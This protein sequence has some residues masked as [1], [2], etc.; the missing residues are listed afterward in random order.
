MTRVRLRYTK[1]GKIRFIG[2]RDLARTWE[3]ALRRSGLAVASTE[4][5]S[6][7]P[8][9]HFGLA[10]STGFESMGEYLDVDLVDGDGAAQSPGGIDDPEGLA[11]ELSDLLPPGIEVQAVAVIGRGRSL[12]DAVVACDWR[13]EFAEVEPELLRQRADALAGEA[14]FA[15]TRERKGSVAT[16]EVRS[17]LEAMEILGPVERAGWDSGVAMFAR[18]GT[19]APALKIAELIDACAPA[20]ADY[21]VLRL[22][23]WIEIEG[24]GARQEPLPLATPLAHAGVHAS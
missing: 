12:Q 13:I 5:F 18:V 22:H 4:G 9:M 6:P 19:V 16:L 15:V 8:K 2:H 7:R 14:T 21:R 3:R 17:S 11:L 24:E 23:Q 1:L 20:V 10:L